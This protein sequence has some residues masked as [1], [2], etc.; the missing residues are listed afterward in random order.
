VGLD[1]DAARLESDERVGDRQS[2]HCRTLGARRTQEGD[3]F[4]PRGEQSDSAPSVTG[5]A[6]KGHSLCYAR[7]EQA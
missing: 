2:E 6:T 1:F 7:C 4:V 5:R 3:P